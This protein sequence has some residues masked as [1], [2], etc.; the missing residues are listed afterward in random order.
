M[1]SLALLLSG[2]LRNLLFSL[3]RRRHT[4]G[5]SVAELIP[6]PKRAGIVAN[7]LF[8]VDIMVICT[9]PKWQ[10]MMQRPRELVSRVCIDGL[11]ETAHDPQIHRQDMQILGE[12]AEDDGY[13]DCAESQNHC[14]EWAGVFGCQSKWC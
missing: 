4:A 12:G 11:E 1:P 5:V 3:S 14:L 7:E 6:P 10:E 2:S 9:R 8:V 13:A